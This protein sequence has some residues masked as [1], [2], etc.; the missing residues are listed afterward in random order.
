MKKKGVII[1]CFCIFISLICTAL[2]ISN[3]GKTPPNY[4]FVSDFEKGI[5][6]ETYDL[7]D[8]ED[9]IQGKKTL[10][11]NTQNKI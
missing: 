5:G 3:L 9:Y 7:Y 2:Y 10:L 1:I 6:T 11:R 4:T 8:V